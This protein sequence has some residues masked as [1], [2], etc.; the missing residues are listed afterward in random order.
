MKLDSLPD[1]NVSGLVTLS[2]FYA[3]QHEAIESALKN[4]Q[5]PPKPTG[6]PRLSNLNNGSTE[7]REIVAA[8]P[9]ATRVELCELFA[10]KTGNWVGRTAMSSTLQ[11]L[12][13]NSK[14]KLSVVANQEQKES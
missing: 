4:S 5:I 3:H 11:K 14:K 9:D 6:K 2:D 7:V 13:L 8:H 12:G 1:R 10:K